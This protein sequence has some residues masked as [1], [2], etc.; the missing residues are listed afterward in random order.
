MVPRIPIQGSFALALQ[1][2][3]SF[4]DDLKSLISTF[5]RIDSIKGGGGGGE[6]TD[7]LL[8]LRVKLRI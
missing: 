1:N 2:V 5:K 8:K 4:L 3:L 6:R 7:S